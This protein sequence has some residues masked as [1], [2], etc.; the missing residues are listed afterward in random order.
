M[1]KARKHTLAQ[2]FTILK[3]L[4]GNQ[5]HFT[6]VLACAGTAVRS[7]EILSLRWNDILW[8]E[9]KIRVSKRW[10]KR[11]DGETKTAASNSTVPLHPILA[12][13]LKQWHINTLHSKPNDF[14]FP[15]LT[16]FGKVPIWPSTFMAD[17]LRPAVKAAGGQVGDG[18]RLGLHNFR[19][20]L[21]TFL[22]NG[23]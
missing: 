21:A 2:T 10:A 19:H 13:Y 5:L 17:Y 14:V 15:S 20:S 11:K 1:E 8:N 9:G 4:A 18:Q 3:K 23:A 12:E 22:S 7:S 16:R 6:L